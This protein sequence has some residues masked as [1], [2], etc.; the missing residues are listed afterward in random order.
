MLRNLLAMPARSWASLNVLSEMG[1]GMLRWVVALHGIFGPAA[2]GLT[3]NYLNVCSRSPQKMW[4]A[5]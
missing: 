1:G 4:V 3:L 2:G 5:A